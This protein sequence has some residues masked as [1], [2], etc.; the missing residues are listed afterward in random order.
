M[1]IMLLVLSQEVLL[2]VTFDACYQ[3]KIKKKIVTCDIIY[4]IMVSYVSFNVKETH[5]L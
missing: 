3:N 4:K 1:L 2:K 5:E